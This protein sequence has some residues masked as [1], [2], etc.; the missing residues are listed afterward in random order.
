MGAASFRFDDADPVF[1]ETKCAVASHV[2]LE[3]D[4]GKNILAAERGDIDLEPLRQHLFERAV[5]FEHD[6]PLPLSARRLIRHCIEA[7]SNKL[8][9]EASLT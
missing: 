6:T 3:P 8:C 2:K 1:I 4:N 5:A 7:I 9:H